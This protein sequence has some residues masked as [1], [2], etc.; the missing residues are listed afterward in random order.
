MGSSLRAIAVGWCLVLL[1]GCA[2]VPLPGC[3]GGLEPRVTAEL[4]FG[5]N[6]G[7]RLGVSETDW[8]RFLAA[9][10][11]PRFPEG[12]TV[13][14]AA[15]QWRDGGRLVREPSKVVLLTLKQPAVDQARIDAIVEAYKQ[16]FRQQ[17]VGVVLR[18]AC[19]SF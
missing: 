7:E 11:T 12:L 5:R 1:A 2:A 16:R 4:L 8:A 13:L 9:E 14:D 15:G 18:P 10:V 19:V 6:V 17:S 3:P